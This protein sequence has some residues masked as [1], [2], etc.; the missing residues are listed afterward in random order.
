VGAVGRVGID[1]SDPARVAV[2]PD[3]LAAWDLPASRCRIVA[4]GEG[5]I[6][7][8]LFVGIG[9][10]WRHL[11][12]RL[13]RQVFPD[14]I[15]IVRNQVHVITH[16]SARAPGFVV[17]LERTRAGEWFYVDGDGEIWRL[18]PFREHSRSVASLAGTDEA[19]AA[20][21][22]FGRFQALARD[23]S[24]DRIAVAIPHFHDLGH[25]LV[26][27]DACVAQAPT[28]LEHAAAE[29]Q[30]V[31]A[32]RHL[33]DCDGPSGIIHADCKVS[34]V[35]FDATSARAIAVVDLD[36]VM[37]GRRAW[38]FGD[39][40]RSALSGN[41][42][43]APSRMSVPIC[44]ALAAGFMAGAGDTIAS[45]A[46]FREALADAPRYMTF[47]LGVRFLIDHLEGDR[48]FRQRAPGD[49]LRRARYQFA[50]VQSLEHARDM[51]ARVLSEA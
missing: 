38:D 13:N 33:A 5:N 44:R 4:A 9:G 11:L 36:T 16:L 2:P 32:R 29:C 1:G 6:N 37:H 12:Q 45:E 26:R 8:S 15:A 19:H 3:V 18:Q 46:G 41:E 50:L 17:P 24:P 10:R 27:F 20:A 21:R 28:R 31:S 49:N 42:R 48:Y 23:L 7:T 30:F 22:A 43:D 39:L 34:N 14:P 35:L 47:M 40:V 25:Q 51:L